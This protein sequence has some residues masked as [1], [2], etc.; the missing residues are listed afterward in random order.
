MCLQKKGVGKSENKSP[1]K[2]NKGKSSS[3]SSSSDSDSSENEKKP[4]K[5]LMISSFDI[6]YKYFINRFP[7]LENRM[8]FCN[9]FP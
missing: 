1:K 5:V 2:K 4:N 6:C 9:V 3:F 8:E 7:F